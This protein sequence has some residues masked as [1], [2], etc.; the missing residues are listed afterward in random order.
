MTR[1]LIGAAI[2][3]LLLTSA[4]AAQNELA[5]QQRTIV[6]PVAPPAAAVTQVG[7]NAFMVTPI[8]GLVAATRVK[9]QNFT[10]YDLNADGA[11]SPMEFGQAIY[12]LATTDPVA[13]N[14]KLPS[15]DR[16]V[17]R[18]APQKMAPANA[19]MLLNATADEFAAA[20]LNN[21][22]RV[23]PDELVAVAML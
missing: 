12:F 9:V 3:G 6:A 8:P 4:A 15:M 21:D 11:Y 1:H 18:G 7:P 5:P 22:W 2:A 17:H 19:I 14:P 23:T 13:G 20:D 10:D 16:T